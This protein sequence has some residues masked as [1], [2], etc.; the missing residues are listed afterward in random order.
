MPLISDDSITINSI[1]MTDYAST[2]APATPA[3]GKSRVFTR[4]DGLYYMDDAGA[5]TGPMA[6]GFSNPMTTAG[7]I[8]YGGASG[9]PTRLAVG[10]A[11]QVL[12]VNAG[13]TAPEWAA[14][15][16]GGGTYI[17]DELYDNT[18]GSAGT[19]DVSS[20]SQDYDHLE[21][22]FT[23]RS[24]RASAYDNA[25]ILFNNDSTASNYYR[26]LHQAGNNTTT[27]SVG[28]TTSPV[29]ITS[30]GDSAL[31]NSF[32]IATVRIPYYTSGMLKLARCVSEGYVGAAE[33]YNWDAS[34]KWANTAA[35]NRI[36]IS[37]ETGTNFITG[38]RLQ[39]FGLK[40]A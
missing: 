22:I 1:P 37:P 10:T 8:I 2:A 36:Q 29:C 33:G 38:C 27:H 7:D 14:A 30:V 12:T 23:H 4:A 5:E 6:A 35:I 3:S 17:R 28:G 34:L 39:I 32:A 21:L 9:T 11:A 25:K 13:A 18:L 19:W 26:Q 20:I 31:A 24:D 16:A 15:A 40:G